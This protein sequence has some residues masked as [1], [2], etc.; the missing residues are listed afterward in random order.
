[1]EA[2]GALPHT[3]PFAFESSS[4]ND[5]ENEIE[6]ESLSQ[7]I[8]QKI[9][10]CYEVNGVNHQ[11]EKFEVMHTST[12]KT[13]PTRLVIRRGQE[14][15]LKLICNRPINPKMD[16]ISLVLAVDPIANEWISYGH[17][18]V[19]YLLLQ[20]DDNPEEEHDSDWSAKL[21]S[22][23]VNEDGDTELLVAISTSPNASVSKWT[24]T[25]NIKSKRSE[26]I[27]SH[28]VLKPFYLLFNPWC[29]EDPV[30][31]DNEDQ[32]KEY[33]LE[34]MTTIWR[35]HKRSFY[36]RKW[37]L[38][39]YEANIL[40]VTLSILGKMARVSATYRGNP[41]KV[42]R[43]LAGIV[44]SQ[45]DAGILLGNWSTNSR[46]GTAPSAWTGSVKI[47]KQYSETERPVGY[48]QCW[49][50]AGVLATLCRALGIPCRIVT[51]FS[52]AQDSAASLTVDTYFNEEGNILENFSRD[53]VWN[54][55]VW[56]EV[57]MKRPDI[58]KE[59]FDGWQVI[60]GTPLELSDGAYKLGPA[61][62]LAV[63]N[64]LV[65]ILYDCSLV[66][67]AVNADQVYWRYR[68]SSKPLKLIRKDTTAIGKYI[69]TK[70]VGVDEREDIV[71]N[72]KC[73]EESLKAKT[74]MVRAL[75]LGQNCLTKHYLKQ[76]DSE[77]RTVEGCD[78]KFELE[79]NHET[80]IGQSFNIV[81]RIRNVSLD[82]PYT[83]KGRI[84]LNHI[85]YTGKSIRIIKSNTFCIRIKPN[86][87]QTNL[88]PITFDDY[89]KPGMDEAIFKVISTA[90]IEGL[91][92]NYFS[93]DDY[94]LCKPIVQLQLRGTPV[95]NSSVPVLAKFDNPLPVAIKGG[96]FHIECSGIGGTFTK[97]VAPIGARMPYEDSFLIVPS[98]AGHN[99]LSI[100]F[101]SNELNDVEGLLSFVV[102]DRKEDVKPVVC[103]FEPR[104]S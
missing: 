93:Q 49:V 89:Y 69:I 16:T 24:M 67:S 99:Q 62:V 26:L 57:W 19:V 42:C 54:F 33:V 59:Q 45:D 58:G 65:N 34:D 43:A 13:G 30:Y 31:L 27:S 103:R 87:E 38:G 12:N 10:L 71:N 64:G 44:N 91:D 85:L 41:I 40:D 35:G 4:E 98:F 1:M 61:P 2:N 104:S 56:N 92:Y 17:G 78:V 82:K 46:G 94:R 11:T 79:L 70:A 48:G 37:K 29:V 75:K 7:L 51:N 14:F 8:I 18:S 53:Q 76:L 95:I 20:T 6:N 77:D 88:V 74:V 52:S 28:P 3:L 81:L 100:K 84:L 15:L 97:E 22:T 90:T 96:F 50:Y 83:V 36:L 66:F 5:N 23:T 102:E 32:R 73:N 25:I 72:Y 80:L 63:K 21:Q 47:L 39:Q 101:V 9:D 86:G 55:H 60:D 68:G